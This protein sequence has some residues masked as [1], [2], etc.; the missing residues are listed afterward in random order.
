MSK[1]KEINILFVITSLAGGGAERV[2]VNLS[3]AWVKKGIKVTIV[4]ISDNKQDFYELDERIQRIGLNVDGLSK[5]SLIGILSN[6][7]RVLA[8]RRILQKQK[9]DIILGMMPVSAILTIIANFGLNH[10]VIACERNYPP[11]ARMNSFWTKLRAIIYPYATAIAVQTSGVKSWMEENIKVKRIKVIPNPVIY[12]LPVTSPIIL[13]SKI[14]ASKQKLL[15]ATGRLTQQKGFDVLIS[16]F[17]SLEKQFKNWTLVILGEGENRLLLEDQIK[18]EGLEKSIILLGRVGNL[19]DWYKRADIYVMSS[20][21]EG[22]PNTLAE[23]MSYGCPVVSFD[24]K[25]GPSDLIIDNIDGVLVKSIGDVKA[26]ASAL[27]GVM[28]NETLRNTFS[29]NAVEVRER[30]SLSSILEK[31]ENFF[32]DLLEIK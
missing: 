13:P 6:I 20:L 22:F 9:P 24:C 18:N 19:S 25:T 15:L 5:N 2:T 14:L 17:S 30:Y 11:M 12:P 21:F 1:S 16:A 29:K 26:L 31:W 3:N 4:T 27:K 7:K 8:I 23:A 32:I 28:S 10:K